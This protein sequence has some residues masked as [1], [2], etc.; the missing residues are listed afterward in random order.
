[1]IYEDPRLK[2]RGLRF[3]RLGLRTSGGLNTIVKGVKVRLL[4]EGGV[5]S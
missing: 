1:V 3:R 5:E 4:V 2:T